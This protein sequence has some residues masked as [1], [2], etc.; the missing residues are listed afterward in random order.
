MATDGTVVVHG[1]GGG[2]APDLTLMH[3]VLAGLRRL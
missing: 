1:N 3:R 2:H